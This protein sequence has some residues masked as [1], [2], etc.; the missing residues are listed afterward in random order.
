MYNLQFSTGSFGLTCARLCPGQRWKN[1]TSSAAPCKVMETRSEPLTSLQQTSRHGRLFR[2]RAPSHGVW[3]RNP[4]LATTPVTV[5][6]EAKRCELY[7]VRQLIDFGLFVCCFFLFRLM[8]HRA[9]LFFP[10][11]STSNEGKCCK[12]CAYLRL[13]VEEAMTHSLT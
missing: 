1:R 6:T 11:L 7:K 8:I 4:L 13:L 5:L 3:R 12:H 9:S 10:G 2:P